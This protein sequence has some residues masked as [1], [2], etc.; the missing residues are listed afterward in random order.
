M[1]Q[2]PL[3]VFQ[4]AVDTQL[5]RTI[6]PASKKYLGKKLRAGPKITIVEEL[7]ASMTSIDALPMMIEA[8]EKSPG[9]ERLPDGKVKATKTTATQECYKIKLQNPAHIAHFCQ[10]EV[11]CPLRGFR[12]AMLI[13]KKG[14]PGRRVAMAA[15]PLILTCKIPRGV[16]RRERLPTFSYR[17]NVILMDENGDVTFGNKD[18]P[19]PVRGVGRQLPLGTP[20]LQCIVVLEGS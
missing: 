20:L 15:G 3:A 16:A 18:Y 11:R 5:A 8:T 12:G 19:P 17:M 10:M 9:M 7:W 14:L 2:V 13:K 6:R 1:V 4:K